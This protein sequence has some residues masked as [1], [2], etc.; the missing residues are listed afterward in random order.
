VHLVDSLGASL[1][2]G[3]LVLKACELAELAHSP[4]DIARELRRIRSRSGILFTVDT[5]DRLLASGR[6]GR[7]RAL[8]GSMLSVKPILS[9]DAA[10]KVVPAGKAMGRRRAQDALLEA[11]AERIPEEAK[12]RFGIV[13]VGDD[14][15]VTPVSGAL[16]SRYGYDVE[17]LASPAT[18]VIATHIGTGAWG[19]AYLL[20]D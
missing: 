3:L 2:Q 14:S 11:L 8:L 16:R 20:E 12:V 17:I 10:G 6:V 18:P 1:L 9:L 4:E 19:V 13:Y 15:I 5:F 7:G